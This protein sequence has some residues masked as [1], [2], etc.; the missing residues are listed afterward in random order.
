MGRSLHHRKG[1]YET[2]HGLLFTLVRIEGERNAIKK[3]Y[4]KA[5]REWKK[6]KRKRTVK[7]GE[8]LKKKIT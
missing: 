2:R 3:I 1:F 5:E 8:T 7:Q 6:I 4:I